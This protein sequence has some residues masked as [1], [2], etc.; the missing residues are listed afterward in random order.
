MKKL[1]FAIAVIALCSITKV[2]EAGNRT[3]TAGVLMTLENETIY[4][5]NKISLVSDA[6]GYLDENGKERWRKM[7]EMKYMISGDRVWCAM[8]LKPN[9]RR[10]RLVEILAMNSKYLLVNHWQEGD[11]LFI[12]DYDGNKMDTDLKS[13]ISGLGK[14]YDEKNMEIIGEYFGKCKELLDKLKKNHEM[15]YM[16]SMYGVNAM[17][18]DGAPDMEKFLATYKGKEVV[19]D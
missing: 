9:H 4:M 19:K 16:P 6:V 15:K 8:P 13:A 18:C 1:K 2:S 11:H 14:K 3:D 7:N 10:Y 17:Q 12:Y 5:F